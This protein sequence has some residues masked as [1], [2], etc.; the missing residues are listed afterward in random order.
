VEEGSPLYYLVLG[1]IAGI[2]EQ[3]FLQNY[4]AYLLL[5]IF[6]KISKFIRFVIRRLH[7]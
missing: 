4:Y 3:F 5:E 7:V 2:F 1:N 6:V